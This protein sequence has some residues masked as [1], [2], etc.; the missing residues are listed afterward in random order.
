MPNP[1]NDNPGHE[2]KP[3]MEQER[4]PLFSS[5]KKWYALVLLHLAFLIVVFY[6]FTKAFE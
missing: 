1:L 3:E 5:W 6:L 4:P 2:I